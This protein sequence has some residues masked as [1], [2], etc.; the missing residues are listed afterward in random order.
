MP[1]PFNFE[2]NEQERKEA[3]VIAHDMGSKIKNA[4]NGKIQVNIENFEEWKKGLEAIYEVAHPRSIEYF[5]DNP[6]ELEKLIRE[7]T[8]SKV[9][10]VAS[11]ETGEIP[12]YVEEE[13]SNYISDLSPYLEILKNKLPKVYHNV[14]KFIN[15]AF[16]N[17][18]GI[19]AEQQ[20]KELPILER[21]YT[22]LP[23]D[24][25]LNDFKKT[26][27][28]KD[29]R[30]Q[31]QL[32][33]ETLSYTQGNITIQIPHYEEL[34]QKSSMKGTE[35]NTPVK[36]LLD[37][38]TALF[39]ETHSPVVKFSLDDYM[40]LCGLKDKKE[41]RKQVN[42]A[43][44]V[45][46]DI[47]ISYD[48][49]KNKN[50][51]RNYRD[52]RLVDDKGIERGIIRIRF[53]GGFA[54]ELEKM[55]LMPYPLEILK[56]SQ[57]R[58]HRNSF[59]IASWLCVLKNMNAGKNNE[60]VISVK[61]L[62]N[63]CPFLPTEEEVRSSE[64]RSLKERIIN[65]FISD[66]EEALKILG[67]GEDGYEWHYEG[68]REIPFDKLTELDYETFIDAYIC[69][70]EWLDYPELSVLE[71]KEKRIQ[72]ALNASKKKSTGKDKKS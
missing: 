69:I 50:R 18:Q 52:M 38:S 63:H 2:M 49:S 62:L 53:A 1:I 47:S 70:D 71:N 15:N 5:S 24:N 23:Q 27:Q 58:E 13:K 67:I 55:P 65:P 21:M 32:W 14:I 40:K 22:K 60:Y 42:A 44:D 10:V 48:D 35:L 54:E 6:S 28:L 45:L 68:G 8:I 61:S 31:L 59:Y 66:F 20:D 30:G 72:R 37:I 4:L 25:M 51:S 16:D 64:F 9:Y 29:T 11:S 46:Y 19:L 43:L 57:G 33:A 34:L 41:S 3:M 36:K 12:N 26:A 56:L 39:A 17:R 7:E